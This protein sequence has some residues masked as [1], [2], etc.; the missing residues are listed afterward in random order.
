MTALKQTD[1]GAVTTAAPMNKDAALA[2]DGRGVSFD[3][4][5]KAKQN[6]FDAPFPTTEFT[7]HSYHNLTG[8][9]FQKVV[10]L[11]VRAKRRHGD[12]HITWVCRCDCGRYCNYK[13]SKLRERQAAGLCM[14]SECEYLESVKAGTHPTKEQQEARVVS[15]AEKRERMNGL[16]RL[17]HP[18]LEE[19]RAAFVALGFTENEY[20]IAVADWMRI[21]VDAYRAAKA[22]GF[23]KEVGG[24]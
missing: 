3:M 8:Q 19:L 2:R 13:A 14:C 22:N 10:V 9:R 16:K 7:G 20:R 6:A 17:V 21:Q 23:A 4:P 15:A 5:P 12:E 11:G 1:W 18:K 24:G